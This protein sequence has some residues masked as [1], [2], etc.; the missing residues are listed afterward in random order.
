MKD[1][2]AELNCIL[3]VAVLLLHLADSA[4][5]ESECSARCQENNPEELEGTARLMFSVC[6]SGPWENPIDSAAH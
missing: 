5:N 3:E 6:V 1:V 2:N 4:F